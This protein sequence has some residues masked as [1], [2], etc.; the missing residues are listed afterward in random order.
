MTLEGPPGGSGHAGPDRDADRT[1]SD[2]TEE[3]PPPVPHGS[4]HNGSILMAAM[5]GLGQA[6]GMDEEVKQ[7][8]PEAVMDD[9]HG[10]PRF[11]LDFG[12]LDPL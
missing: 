6:L 3:L 10:P 2:R 7:E 1:M 9:P 12:G 11:D 5:L 4:R 8:V